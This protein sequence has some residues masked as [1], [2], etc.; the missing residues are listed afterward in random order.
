MRDLRT[1]TFLPFQS[2]EPGAFV[3]AF[4]LFKLEQYIERRHANVCLT[5]GANMSASL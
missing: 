5:A 4:Q 1:S 3:A 2:K